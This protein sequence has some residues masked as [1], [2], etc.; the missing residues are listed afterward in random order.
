[1][2]EKIL[3]KYTL[4]I[5]TLSPVHIGDGGELTPLD[6]VMRDRI[7]HV[8]DEDRLFE[9]LEGRR[10]VNRFIN[11][12]ESNSRVSLE[13]FIKRFMRSVAPKFY[14]DLTKYSLEVLSERIKGR[15]ISTFIKNADGKAYI[16]G[17][18]IK[19]AIRIAL[20]HSILEKDPAKIPLVLRMI[21]NDNPDEDALLRPRIGEPHGDLGRLIRPSDSTAIDRLCVA[22]MYRASIKLVRLIPL[23]L[24]EVIPENVTARAELT[25]I[26]SRKVISEIG[27]SVSIQEIAKACIKKARAV[28]ELE[29][30][31]ISR[32]IR[33]KS[34]DVWA[35]LNRFYDDLLRKL[36]QCGE[37]EALLRIGGGQGLY[38]TTLVS[39]LMKDASFKGII[40]AREVE[41]GRRLRQV[42]RLLLGGRPYNVKVVDVNGR[43]MPLGWIKVVFKEA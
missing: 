31:R 1:L 38:S 18:E 39:A 17:S 14:E 26:S 42:R 16:P 36:D 20:L 9:E 30:N 15:Q 13:D 11:H 41:G 7:I 10:L 28:I 27:G 40:E 2:S 23:S 21:I 22:Q 19:G 5:T 12:I 35:M 43:L 32:I 34:E 29:K 6:Y 3:E 25:L 4:E 37:T 33:E 8:I 24:V